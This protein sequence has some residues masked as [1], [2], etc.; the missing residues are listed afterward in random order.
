MFN[1]RAIKE[2]LEH[3]RPER[4]P[5]PVLVVESASGEAIHVPEPI[6]RDE[7]LDLAQP[8]VIAAVEAAR[9]AAKR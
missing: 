7:L 3:D 1:N 5:D 9:R 2:M 4:E 8:D 6:G